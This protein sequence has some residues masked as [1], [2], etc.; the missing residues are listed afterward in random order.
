MP[1]LILISTSSRR[2]PM[3]MDM[4][5]TKRASEYLDG[6]AD[7]SAYIS[8]D[9]DLQIYRRFTRLGA[10]NL[11]HLQSEL[12]R[13]ER[14]FDEFDQEDAQG[15]ANASQPERMDIWLRNRNWET[16]VGMAQ[17]GAD[18]ASSAE[19][20]RQAKKLEMV[21]RLKVVMAEYRIASRG[22]PISRLSS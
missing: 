15:L 7:F 1:I 22:S 4:A 17:A 21:E 18:P 10:R 12:T 6:H 16:F 14:W 8:I 13:L 20:K 2:G 19:Q 3:A 9:S 11:L 5:A